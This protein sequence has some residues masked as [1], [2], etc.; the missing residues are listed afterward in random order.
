MSTWVTLEIIL[1]R[2]KQVGSFSNIREAIML[3]IIL[4]GSQLRVLLPIP[5]PAKFT[6]ELIHR[7]ILTRIV[8]L[9][10]VEL[11]KCSRRVN[12]WIK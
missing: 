12:C 5:I 6:N 3:K 1:L 7:R 4:Q 11:K 8:S 2:L 10:M 9:S